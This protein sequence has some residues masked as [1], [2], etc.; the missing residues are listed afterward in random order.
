MSSLRH[1]HTYSKFKARPGYFKCNDPGCTHFLIREQVI[2]KYS[3]CNACGEEF[4]LDY[5]SI[6]LAMPKCLS[7]RSSKRA[8]AFQLGKKL[9]AAAFSVGP[10][11]EVEEDG[12]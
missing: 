12:D 5:D 11:M 4:V 2:G 10:G 7:C 6:S 1:I 9:A 3:R 8:K